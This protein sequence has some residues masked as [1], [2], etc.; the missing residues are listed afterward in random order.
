[1]ILYTTKVI[2]RSISILKVTRGDLGSQFECPLWNV[3]LGIAVAL[4]LYNYCMNYISL[5]LENYHII[6]LNTI[7]HLNNFQDGRK[8]Q[9]GPQ[10]EDYSHIYTYNIYI[11]TILHSCNHAVVGVRIIR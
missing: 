3:F 4:R 5:S 10:I 7:I 9:N 8:I 11:V 6:M 2:L 1:M